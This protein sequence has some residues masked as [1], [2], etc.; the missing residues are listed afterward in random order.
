MAALSLYISLTAFCVLAIT[1]YKDT[2]LIHSFCRYYGFFFNS[3]FPGGLNS[4]TY[5][6]NL[7]YYLHL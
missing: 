3:C 2:V 1:N 5:E 6:N 7:K 4:K